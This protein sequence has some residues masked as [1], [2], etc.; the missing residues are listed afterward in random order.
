MPSLD[1]IGW[2]EVEQAE[3]KIADLVERRV[4]LSYQHD[5]SN[6]LADK[7]TLQVYFHPCLIDSNFQC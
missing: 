5:G 7:F 2:L 4:Q 1:T 6:E 3:V